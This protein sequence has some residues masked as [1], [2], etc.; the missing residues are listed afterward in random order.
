MTGAMEEPDPS[1][2]PHLSGK[3]PLRKQVL[4]RLMDDGSIDS[5]FDP[6]K[7]KRLTCLDRV[8]QLPLSF[9][10]ATTDPRSGHV[11]KIAGLGI[12]R[13]DIENDQRIGE[14]RTRSA[15]VRITPL[16]ATGYDGAVWR[17]A[18]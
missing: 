4:D 3:S 7:R 9:T 8:P 18:R 5:G 1:A 14:K 2:F 6:S 16:I 13:K 11:A 12:T 10:R 17:S 15:L